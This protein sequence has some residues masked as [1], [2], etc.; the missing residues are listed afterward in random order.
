MW[1]SV[2]FINVSNE[3]CVQILEETTTVYL[4]L[5]FLIK[6]TRKFLVAVM[7]QLLTAKKEC[8]YSFE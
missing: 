3:I 8:Q 6:V 5:I 1:C 2:T 7:S 4:S